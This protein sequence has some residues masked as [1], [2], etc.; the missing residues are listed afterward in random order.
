[1]SNA[2]VLRHFDR[3]ECGAFRRPHRRDLSVDVVVTA[4]AS[5]ADAR[6]CQRSARSPS[7]NAIV[8]SA[9]KSHERH[10]TYATDRLRTPRKAIRETTR[11][12]RRRTRPS[13]HRRESSKRKASCGFGRVPG[14]LYLSEITSAPRRAGASDRDRVRRQPWLRGPRSAEVVRLAARYR[15]RGRHQPLNICPAWPTSFTVTGA[16]ARA[17]RSGTPTSSP[18]SRRSAHADV[19]DLVVATHN[20]TRH[21]RLARATPNQPPFTLVVAGR[22]L[23]A[24]SQ[25]LLGHRTA[26]SLSAAPCLRPP[27]ARRRS[28]RRVDDTRRRFTSQDGYV[29]LPE[30]TFMLVRAVIER[31][32]VYCRGAPGSCATGFAATATGTLG[33]LM[34]ADFVMGRSNLGG[35]SMSAFAGDRRTEGEQ[36]LP[37]CPSGLTESGRVDRRRATREII[38]M[39]TADG[40]GLSAVDGRHHAVPVC[41]HGVL[42]A[43]EPRGL[44]M[45]L[46]MPRVALQRGG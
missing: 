34:A 33:G 46:S 8:R 37:A 4:V 2:A 21:G 29:A 16:R 41:P 36:G 17:Q 15:F 6:S 5:R 22:A 20:P 13:M 24:W 45:G 9:K 18:P 1:M 27:L 43:V 26:V 10:L 30:V 42:R 44:D 7:S 19:H 23:W 28:Q 14:H 39:S 11:G 31:S 40:R 3:S 25:T 38:G 12:R 32:T 35:L